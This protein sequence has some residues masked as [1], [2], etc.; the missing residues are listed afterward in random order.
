MADFVIRLLNFSP[1]HVF[2]FSLMMGDSRVRKKV[3]GENM[4]LMTAMT[5]FITAALWGENVSQS[6]LHNNVPTDMMSLRLK[7]CLSW[8][9]FSAVF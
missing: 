9:I 6:S 2:S 7:R 4:N 5:N 1:W 3:R 8:K